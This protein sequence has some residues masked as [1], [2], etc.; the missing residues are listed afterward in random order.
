MVPV[1]YRRIVVCSLSYGTV[2]SFHGDKTVLPAVNAYAF[3]A[4]DTKT[5]PHGRS[6]RYDN[7]QT[8]ILRHGTGTVLYLEAKEK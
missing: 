8:T 3:A 7:E 4:G 2:R 6:V 5:C 1:P